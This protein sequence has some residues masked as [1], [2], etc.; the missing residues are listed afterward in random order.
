MKDIYL[1]K[2]TCV[3]EHKYGNKAS[4]LTELWY[5]KV[6]FIAGFSKEHWQLMLQRPTFPTGF[7]GGLK[8][9]YEG[10]GSARAQFS[11]W[12]ASR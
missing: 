6:Q 8:G 11:D 12:L 9:Q 7:Q 5:R 4:L 10:V 1:Y 2:G 3:T